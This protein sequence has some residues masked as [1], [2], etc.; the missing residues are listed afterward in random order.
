MSFA[1]KHLTVKQIKCLF[2]P[3]HILYQIAWNVLVTHGLQTCLH[4]SVN[5]TR[6]FRCFNS[7]SNYHFCHIL[8]FFTVSFPICILFYQLPEKINN[9]AMV[10]NQPLEYSHFWLS[11]YF[12]EPCLIKLIESFE[13]PC[14]I[15]KMAQNQ[16]FKTTTHSL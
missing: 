7:V 6:C 16:R 10:L 3:C 14:E 15:L 2:I 11:G 4:H 12:G 8:S 9:F 13:H 5:K 1:T